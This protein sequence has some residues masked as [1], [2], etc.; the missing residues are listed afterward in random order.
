MKNDLTI[1]TNVLFLLPTNSHHSEQFHGHIMVLTTF[2]LSVFPHVLYNVTL[3]TC[4]IF[5]VIT[6]R[7][8]IIYAT[9]CLDSLIEKGYQ[10]YTYCNILYT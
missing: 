1:H 4:R 2:I 6:I 3:D 5:H 10:Y 8:N 7:Q 9:Y